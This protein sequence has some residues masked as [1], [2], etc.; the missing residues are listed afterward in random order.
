MKLTKS[1]R[2]TIRRNILSDMPPM[3]DYKEQAQELTWTDSLAQ[4]PQE[5][6]DA[7]SVNP[8]VKN[9]LDVESNYIAECGCMYL[10]SYKHYKAS[11]ETTKEVVRLHGLIEEDQNKM[12]E[13]KG[14]LYAILEACTTVEMFAK[15]YPEFTSYIPKEDQPIRNLP[16]VNL[17]NEMKTLG[18]AQK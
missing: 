1:M 15:N 13:I 16:A 18:W 14:N 5:L 2:D 3:P 10:R 9:Y 17:I 6:K 11:P 4:L 7:I 8:D 12:R